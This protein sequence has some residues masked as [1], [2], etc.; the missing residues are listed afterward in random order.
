[1]PS[2]LKKS[3]EG[4]AEI[5]IEADEKLLTKVKKDTLK[6]LQPEV[7]APG[8][9]Q[10]KAPLHIVEKQVDEKYFHSRFL[11]E[12]LNQLFIEAL[13]EHKLRTLSGPEVEV[14]SFVPF[15][16]LTFV[17]KV[18]IV[19][20]IKLADLSKLSVE[21]PKPKVEAKDIT[22]VLDQLKERMAETKEVKRAAKK[23]DEVI[24]DFEGFDEAKA[25]VGGAQGND[26]PLK[27][28]SNTFIP[29]FEDKLIGAK[30]AQTKEFELTF[31][32][33]YG[34]APLANKKVTFK[35]TVKKVNER[36]EP[37]L[38]D[39]FAQS[40]GPFKTLDDL[41]A[42]IKTH[43]ITEQDQKAETKYR[44]MLVDELVAKSKITAP[45]SLVKEHE[46]QML[47]ELSQ[48]LL[49]RG[50]TID[51]YLKEQKMSHEKLVETEIRPQA[52]HRVKCG[53]ALAEIADQQKMEVSEDERKVRTALLKEQYP[54][55]Q[56][57]REL[58]TPPAQ[59]KIASQIMTEKALNFLVQS[60]G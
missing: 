7:S 58:D 35:V 50:Q 52:E 6:K 27:L 54:D 25:P 15:S 57:K 32:A 4:Q 41:K 33:D 53:L 29:G 56:M 60:A 55:E 9:R 49:Y 12:A 48:N 17:A 38:D 14:K 11:D 30:P 24:I 51:E 59:Q 1:M 23:G 34:H 8:F 46:A 3:A 13:S 18:E 22:T 37:K 10:G 36:A 31:P 20:D 47:Q 39:K 42:D 16:Q 2:K 19:P 26:Y 40:I 21:K 5:H 28:G 43:L 44:D 45:E